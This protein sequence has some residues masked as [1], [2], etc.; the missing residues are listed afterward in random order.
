MTE[1]EVKTKADI[2]YI[3][4][5]FKDKGEHTNRLNLII[6][7]VNIIDKWLLIPELYSVEQLAMIIYKS[8][9]RLR[10]VLESDLSHD[11]K[12]IAILELPKSNS[13]WQTYFFTAKNNPEI[14]KEISEKRQK[15]RRKKL[16]LMTE[17]EL[18]E[19]KAKENARRSGYRK[20]KAAAIL[21]AKI[22]TLGSSNSQYQRMTDEEKFLYKAKVM[23]REKQKH[24]NLTPE[25]SEQVRQRKRDYAAT[26]YATM[27]SEKKRILLDKQNI[28]TKARYANL[29]KEKKKLI[30]DQQDKNS[31][32]KEATIDDVNSNLVG[33]RKIEEVRVEEIMQTPVV[34]ENILQRVVHQVIKRFQ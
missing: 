34:K 21:Q 31:K 11:D 14:G 15:W 1:F 23:E 2:K 19:Y 18:K 12:I 25:E 4:K 9:P 3:V 33:V 26:R 28:K 10:E 7:R 29:I 30:I 5:H 24:S 8:P 20:A 6:S 13:A 16:A 17:E 27:S 22:K 32:T